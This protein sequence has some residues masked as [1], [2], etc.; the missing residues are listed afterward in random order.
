VVASE[1]WPLL[2]SHAVWSFFLRLS[3]SE[4]LGGV[5]G[6]LV[7]VNAEQPRSLGEPV[8]AEWALICTAH[9]ITKLAKAI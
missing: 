8:Q 1:R 3:L 7:K 4:E 5:G 9:N 6:D 2:R